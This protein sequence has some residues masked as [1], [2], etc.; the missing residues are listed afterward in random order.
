MDPHVRVLLPEEIC[1]RLPVFS[2][3]VVWEETPYPLPVGLPMDVLTELP[4][5]HCVMKAPGHGFVLLLATRGGPALSG[6]PFRLGISHQACMLAP[7]PEV[8]ALRDP[9]P[10]LT[11]PENAQCLRKND[12]G[13]NKGYLR[14]PTP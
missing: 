13:K 10:D 8:H 9:R 3:L 4:Q 6:S 5:E 14:V 11:G 12:V 2:A 1:N 7:L